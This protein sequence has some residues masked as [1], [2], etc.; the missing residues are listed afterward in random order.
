MKKFTLLILFCSFCC[1]AQTN[2]SNLVYD[3]SGTAWSADTDTAY[4]WAGFGIGLVFYGLGMVLRVAR[5][6]TGHGD[7]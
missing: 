6:T 3:P 7:F 5:R 1:M 4:F 2:D